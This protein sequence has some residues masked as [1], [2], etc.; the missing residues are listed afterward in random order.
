MQ[1]LFGG[2]DHIGT[3]LCNH[4]DGSGGVSRGDGGHHRPIGDADIP[5][6]NHLQL[7]IHHRT[8]VR[9]Q[10]HLTRAHWMEDCSPDVYE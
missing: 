6:P 7:G 1:S 10:S 8:L 5:A 3:L 9:L 4:H 2:E